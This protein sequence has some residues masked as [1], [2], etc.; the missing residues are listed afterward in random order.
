MFYV[1]VDSNPADDS[2][3]ALQS[4]ILPAPAGVFNATDNLEDPAV[5]GPEQKSWRSKFYLPIT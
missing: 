4:W 2:L 3:L 1:M 5:C